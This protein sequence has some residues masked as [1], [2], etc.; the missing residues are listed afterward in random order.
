MF[1]NFLKNPYAAKSP[2]NSE[3]PSEDLAPVVY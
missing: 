2:N 3:P 1:Y